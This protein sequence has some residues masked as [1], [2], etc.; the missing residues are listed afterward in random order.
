MILLAEID[1]AGWTM[2]I[3]AV[4]GGLAMLAT[5]VATLVM[6]YRGNKKNEQV[7]TAAGIAA[8]SASQAVVVAEETASKNEVVLEKIVIENK[9]IHKLV[10]SAAL[11]L[12]REAMVTLR[13]V[14]DLTVG[15]AD[16]ADNVKAANLAEF[17]YRDHE[18]RQR[19]VDDTR[20]RNLHES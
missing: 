13:R 9:A 12:L 7:A 18:A 1:A 3:G 8:V 17:A 14:A 6:Q 5:Q 16:H 2:I 19:V 15:Q 4:F 10:N 20:E 11:N